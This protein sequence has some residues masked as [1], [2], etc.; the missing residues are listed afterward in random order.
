MNSTTQ[1]TQEQK[2][3]MYNYHKD[4]LRN[5]RGYGGSIIKRVRERYNLTCEEA[6]EVLEEVKLLNRQRR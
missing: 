6:M 4:L 2:I 3:E 1:L 5:D